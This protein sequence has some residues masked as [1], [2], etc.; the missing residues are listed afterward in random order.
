MGIP[1]CSGPYN[2]CYGAFMFNAFSWQVTVISLPLPETTIAPENRPLEKEIPIG[3]HHFQGRTVS[4]REGNRGQIPSKVVCIPSVQ[5]EYLHVLWIHKF[6]RP[7]KDG[8][9]NNPLVD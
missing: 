1:K 9:V 7:S 5:N 6:H 3:N 2:E 8:I 4:F